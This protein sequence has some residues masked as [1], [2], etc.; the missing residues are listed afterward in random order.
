LA[1]TTVVEEIP[2]T[3]VLVIRQIPADRLPKRREV[4]FP[5][6]FFI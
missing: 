1:E 3:F 6:A 5:H 4:I 2:Q